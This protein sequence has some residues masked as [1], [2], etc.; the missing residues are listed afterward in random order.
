MFWIKKGVWPEIGV[1]FIEVKKQSCIDSENKDDQLGRNPFQIS[2][3]Y[4]VKEKE[5]AKTAD[6]NKGDGWNI[7]RK[8]PGQIRKEV[9]GIGS[10]KIGRV[11]V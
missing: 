2:R 11:H 1:V 7:L 6:A 5:N 8:A 10:F 3:G 4:E 9:E